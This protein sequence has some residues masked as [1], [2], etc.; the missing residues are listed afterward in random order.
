VTKRF[1]GFRFIHNDINGGYAHG[2][3]LGSKSA[4]G[5]YLLILNPDTAVTETEVDKLLIFARSNQGYSLVSCRQVN[6]NG[7][8]SKATGEFPSFWNLTGFQRS[9]LRIIRR[10]KGKKIQSENVIFPQWVSGSVMLIRK[11]LFQQ[12]K[13]FYEGFWMYY[14]DVDLCKRVLESG[15]KIAFAQDIT[16]E[17]NHG[18]SS[19]INIRTTS[20]TKTEVSVSQHLYVSRHL[21]GAGRI[22]SQ[23]LLVVNNIVSGAVMAIFGVLL[24][25]IP[26]VF[27]RSAIFL[28]LL[29]YYAGAIVRRS[30][31]SQR[32]AL[33]QLGG[34]KKH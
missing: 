13:G 33:C 16:I 10:E 11:D 32:S 25:F 24:F 34:V 17:H 22:L 8:E 6:E 20:V 18:G 5:E 28:R 30:W 2:N 9:L 31:I 23:L 12:F 4:K 1:P 26:L 21:T 14:E 3:N 15:G 19:R 7:R 29:K 27:V